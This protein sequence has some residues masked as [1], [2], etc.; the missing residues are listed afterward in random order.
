MICGVLSRSFDTTYVPPQRTDQ[1]LHICLGYIRPSAGWKKSDRL[2]FWYLSHNYQNPVQCCN[3][4]KHYSK[5]RT[6]VILY[7]ELL[8]Y[9]ISAVDKWTLPVRP[10]GTSHING[11]ILIK[12]RTWNL[13]HTHAIHIDLSGTS[14]IIYRRL[15][16]GTI[17]IGP[18]GNPHS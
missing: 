16:T 12:L 11:L 8:W 6:S 13:V 18:F 7:I 14:H 17:N 2:T 9:S 1:R 5:T 15:K 4:S 3:G 10:S